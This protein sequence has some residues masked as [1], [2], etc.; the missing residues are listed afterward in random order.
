VTGFEKKAKSATFLV[1]LPD[2]R[3]FEVVVIDPSP[4]VLAAQGGWR[5]MKRRASGKRA[6]D[7]LTMIIIWSLLFRRTAVSFGH[8]IIAP[9]PLRR[10]RL[11][12]GR[13]CLQPREN[14][15]HL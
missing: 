3:E 12:M 5:R 14:I 6:R 11:F 1:G 15:R 9:L 4:S 10:V 2:W 13:Y 8:S 7:L